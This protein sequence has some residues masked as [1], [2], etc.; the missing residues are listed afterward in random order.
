MAT[1]NATLNVGC[2]EAISQAELAAANRNWGT[3][4]PDPTSPV[5]NI[6]TGMNV[7]K[8][9]LLGPLFSHPKTGELTFSDVGGANVCE[10]KSKGHPADVV[11][12][13]LEKKFEDDQP[14]PTD[15]PPPFPPPV[16]EVGRSNLVADS[17]PNSPP[18]SAQPMTNGDVLALVKAGLAAEIIIAKIEASRDAFDTSAIALTQLKADGVPDSV[19]LAMVKAKQ[20]N[21]APK[22]Q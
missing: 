17:A 21:P 5:L 20:P 12:K 4:R 11:L 9:V 22:P 7:A 19:M 10:V 14:P 15:Y 16:A 3:T 13:D 6:S 8:A 18:A 2:K 1:G